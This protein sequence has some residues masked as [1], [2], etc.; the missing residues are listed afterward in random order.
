MT[1]I[2]KAILISIENILKWGWNIE[3]L[4]VV[5]RKV[6]LNFFFFDLKCCMFV[7][8]LFVRSVNLERG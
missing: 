8:G 7:V 2:L 6:S 4:V 5:S 3:M 1:R